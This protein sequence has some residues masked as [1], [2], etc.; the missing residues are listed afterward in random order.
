MLIDDSWAYWF[1]K[2]VTKNIVWQYVLLNCWFDYRTLYKVRKE[3]VIIGLCKLNIDSQ[4]LTLYAINFGC[5]S[6]FTDFDNCCK[7]PYRKMSG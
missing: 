4:I 1:E 5:F 2:R 7:I 3:N 6:F